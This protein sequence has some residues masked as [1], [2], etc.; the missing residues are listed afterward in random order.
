MAVQQVSQVQVRRG[1]MQ[2]LGQLTSGEFG[3]A[4]DQL[5]LFIGNGPVSE[6]A[7]YEGITEVM[8]RKSLLEFYTGSGG[9]A[10]LSGLLEFPYRYRGTDGGYEVQTG[11]LPTN[12]TTRA[13]QRKL[14]EAVNVKDFGARGDGLTNDYAAIQRAIDEIY[15][16]RADA[17]P[18]ETR[19]VL[20]FAPGIYL[21]QGELRIPPYA[22]LRAGGKNSVIIRQDSSAATCIFRTTN[23]IGDFNNNI[24]A[25]T[26]PGYVEV[27]GIRFE[28][29][30]TA[31]RIIGIIESASNIVFDRCQFIGTK[32]QPLIT[33][34]T[35]CILISSN[36]L[37]SQN[38]Q[39]LACD[40]AGMDIG[41]GITDN[42]RLEQIVFDRCS[43]SNLMQ[44]IV[45]STNR[46]RSTLGLKVTNS[47][48]NRIKEQAIRTNSNCT[49]VTSS[50]NTFLDVGTNYAVNVSNV[51]SIAAATSVTSVIRF[52][53]NS[54]YSFGDIFLRGYDQDFIVPAVEHAAS[55]VI[56]VDSGTALRLGSTYQ[57]IGRSYLLPTSTISY[58]PINGR[59]LSGTIHYS[60]ERTQRFRSGTITYA[61]DTVANI[62]CY[63]DSYTQVV[64]TDTIIDMRYITLPS[65]GSARKPVLVVQSL[66]VGFGPTVLTFDVR[67]QDF[68]QLTDSSVLSPSLTTVF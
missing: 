39:F 4:V 25:G 33:D 14:D 55:E 37:P 53:G 13:L 35:Y 42:L 44:G 9:S 32:S 68:K 43:F 48:F 65:T 46:I 29:A 3:F 54:S 36:Y 41:V 23:S 11:E 59:L 17:V 61:V 18:N 24:P 28:L 51:A 1:L 31:N 38:L 50:I 20:E 66:T 56:S 34:N 47:V 12:P 27:Q 49:A 45:T 52:S 10:G 5:R 16:R 40:F 22:V 67:S 2:D 58:I 21:V 57:T 63:R 30:S 7:P 62:V 64:S 26:A 19:R 60:V 8:T 6:G 15:G